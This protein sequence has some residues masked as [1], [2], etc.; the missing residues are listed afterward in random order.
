MNRLSHIIKRDGRAA[1]FTKLRI[2]NAIF[3]A[4]V[5]VGERNRD[6]AEALADRVVERIL[7][8]PWADSYPSVEEIQDI[9]E[10]VLIDQG[11]S[12]IAKAYILYRADRAR[13]RSA[14][15][16]RDLRQGDPADGFP[17]VSEEAPAM[18]FR[19]CGIPAQGNLMTLGIFDSGV[20][21]ID[22]HRWAD[23]GEHQVGPP[24]A[25]GRQAIHPVTNALGELTKDIDPITRGRIVRSR[26]ADEVDA[27]GE[28]G[29]IAGAKAR[30][31]LGS[32]GPRSGDR[33]PTADHA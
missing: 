8:L 17:Y 18:W 1:P 11:K 5:A 12:V 21:A 4:A 22:L 20:A 2:T 13:R 9:V 16:T 19:C 23:A 27:G 25:F 7:A 15:E 10:K 30:A 6:E 26:T 33:P 29:G 31:H 24:D 3:R 32:N 14:R 28:G